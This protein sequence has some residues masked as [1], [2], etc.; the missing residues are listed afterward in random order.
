[1]KMDRFSYLERLLTSEETAGE[2]AALPVEQWAELASEFVEMRAKG[3]GRYF[4]VPGTEPAGSP[5]P[6]AK[7]FHIHE[8]PVE[9]WEDELPPATKGGRYFS[10][11]DEGEDDGQETE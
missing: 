6:K 11:P 8:A 10:I 7:Y 1:M 4:R 2:R 3:G 9:P 5:A